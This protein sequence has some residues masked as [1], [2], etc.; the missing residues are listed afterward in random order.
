MF[1]SNVKGELAYLKS[2]IKEEASPNESGVPPYKR[3]NIIYDEYVV[4]ANTKTPQIAAVSYT[5]HGRHE[6]LAQ[7]SPQITCDLVAN[8]LM[9]IRVYYISAEGWLQELCRSDGG[10]WT[11]GSLN[12]SRIKASPESLLTASVD[13][14]NDGEL[15]LY[16]N[17]ENDRMMWCTWVTMGRQAWSS[18]MVNDKY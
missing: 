15:K 14:S 4:T 8:P 1:Y 9:K 7:S 12:N 2:Q 16:Y 18:R 5:M 10:A 17:M 6:V 3:A 11:K 13:Y